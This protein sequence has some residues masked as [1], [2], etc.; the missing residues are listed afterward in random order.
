M[1][2]NIAIENAKTGAVKAVEDKGNEVLQSIPPDF[3]TQMANKVDKQQGIE[4]K[5]KALVVGEDGN[6]TVG[7]AAGGDGIAIINTM[8][9]ASPLVIPDSAER[10]NKG[11]QHDKRLQKIKL[12]LSK[13][14][15]D[16][17]EK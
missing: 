10:V 5:G 4:N 2:A 1:E 17:T 9:G 16:L 3:E 8:S 13:R 12:R 14:L 6:V 15:V 7:E 11:F